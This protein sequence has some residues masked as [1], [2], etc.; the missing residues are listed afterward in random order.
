M[1]VSLLSLLP[2]LAVLA[3]LVL[4]GPSATHAQAA[5]KAPAALPIPAAS[6]AA[7]PLAPLAPLGA[8]RLDPARMRAALDRLQGAQCRNH[9]RALLDAAA[10]QTRSTLWAGLSECAAA[11][12][13][14]GHSS[15]L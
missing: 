1:A 9:T 3:A 5:A 8:L 13:T 4:S 11:T 6:R 12:P 7:S 2:A 15:S 10:N 14:P